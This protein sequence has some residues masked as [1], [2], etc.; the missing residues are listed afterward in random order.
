MESLAELV[1]G[2]RENG[3]AAGCSGARSG[4]RG[5]DGE[6]RQKQSKVR[7]AESECRN[8][9]SVR[10]RH[11]W[12]RTVGCA[13]CVVV[14]MIDGVALAEGQNFAIKFPQLINNRLSG[15]IAT[16][17]NKADSRRDHTPHRPSAPCARAIPPDHEGGATLLQ[18]RPHPKTFPDR[19]TESASHLKI[20]SYRC[21][22]TA[23]TGNFHHD[24]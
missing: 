3:L 18:R 11:R 23:N 19:G 7:N 24:S 4:T 6:L 10:L 21:T 17:P 9:S 14:A 13:G 2:C 15:A 16:R 1:A 22:F 12:A 5:S 20:R 8:S